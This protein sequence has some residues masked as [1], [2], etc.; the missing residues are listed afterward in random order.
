MKSTWKIVLLFERRI[1]V[2][3]RMVM[4]PFVKLGRV[5]DDGETIEGDFYFAVR[6]G[7]VAHVPEKIDQREVN[8]N[9]V[10][11]KVIAAES[12]VMSITSPDG[13]VFELDALVDV[14]L[15]PA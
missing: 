5:G 15:T 2:D 9:I 10:R 3:G 14:E 11:H 13:E 7:K 12:L 6:G 8:G 4:T 1:E